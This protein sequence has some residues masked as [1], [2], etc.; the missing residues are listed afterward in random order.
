MTTAEIIADVAKDWFL[1]VAAV[2]AIGAGVAVALLLTIIPW[3]L[4]LAQIWQSLF[5][6]TPPR[7][8]TDDLT[9][10]RAHEAVGRA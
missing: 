4:G 9:I 5:G 10:R 3:A 8:K 7:R 6:C 2:V 1:T